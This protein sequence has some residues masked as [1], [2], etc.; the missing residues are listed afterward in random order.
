MCIRDSSSNR[1]AVLSVKVVSNSNN[2]PNTFLASLP[3]THSWCACVIPRSINSSRCRSVMS[4]SVTSRTPSRSRV[5]ASTQRIGTPSPIRATAPPHSLAKSL[6][7]GSVAP[8]ATESSGTPKTTLVSGSAVRIVTLPSSFFRALN[9][10]I[11]AVR[12]SAPPAGI[13]AFHQIHIG[14]A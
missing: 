6:S 1:P 2:S 14:F 7:A 12:L 8:G 9:R 3:A 11:H 4:S 13:L 10:H 5:S